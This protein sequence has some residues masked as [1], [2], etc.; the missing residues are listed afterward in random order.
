L[1]LDGLGGIPLGLEIAESLEDNGH[2][3]IYFDCAKQRHRLFYGIRCAGAKLVNKHVQKDGFYLLPKMTGQ[4]LENLVARERPTHILVIGF[5]CKFFDPKE[6]RRI[7]DTHRVS[8][9]IYDTD[10]CNLYDKRREF[11]FFIE[12]ELPVYDRIFS[13]S[14]VT[15]NFFKE[16]RKLPATFLPFGAKPIDISH[17]GDKPIDVLFVGT[18]NLRRIFLL[19]A[20]KDNVTVYGGNRWQRNLPLISSELREKIKDTPVWGNE[21]HNLLAQSKIVLNITNASFY[22]AGTGINLRIFEAVAAGCFLLTDYC[23]EIREVFEIG[24]E[25]DTFRSAEEL[26]EKVR[27]YLEHNDKRID[28]ARRGHEKFLKC[29]TWRTRTEQLWQLI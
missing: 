28:I 4:I 29:H 22:G 12:R 9:F 8:L 16:T 7:A 21:L 18:G 13:F 26:S 1:L 3:V 11:I 5:I 19:E 15:T 25:I 2:D 17:D 10:S 23:D 14:R 20:I 24:K 27:Y 6:L